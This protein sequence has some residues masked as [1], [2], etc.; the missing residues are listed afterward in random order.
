MT[1]Q[2]KIFDTT[3]R[4]GEQSPGCTMNLKEKVVL[5]KQLEALNVDI[6]EAGFAIASEGDFES[7]KTIAQT[8]KNC[9]VASL[10]RAL[11]KDIDRAWEALQYAEHPRIHTFLATSD[12]HLEH[13]L[14]MSREEVLEKAYHAVKYAKGYCND[15]EFSAEDA[16]RTDL[17][18]LSQVVE[19]VI[20]A[21]ATTVNI[22]DTV[23]YTTPNE[24]YKMISYLKEN[25]RGIDN[26]DISVHCH[27]DLGLGVANSLAAIEAGAT[28]IECTVNGI[29]ERAG[30]AALEEIV[31]ALNTRKDQFGAITRINTKEI[32]R[33]SNLLSSITGVNVQPNKAIVGENAFAHESG[34]HQH[35]MLAERSTYE[36][37]TPDSIGL[38]TNK[39]VLG[40]HSGRHAFADRLKTL[41]YDLDKEDLD[42]AFKE[43]KNLV[44]KKKNV[45]DKDLEAIVTKK[46][47]SVP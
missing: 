24:H 13:K 12:I 15:I 38:S 2:I 33:T 25:V 46:S 44:D 42:F 27:N 16:S 6:M 18:Y 41:G 28:Q 43:F 14:K 21:G 11:E 30:N 3:L 1:K 40:K 34:I 35:G 47:I 9:S 23:G 45:Y 5:A 8:I 39:M 7:V 26:I 36:I 20:K 17:D 29:G 4:D 19:T 22:P 32:M 31:M 37:M 10:A